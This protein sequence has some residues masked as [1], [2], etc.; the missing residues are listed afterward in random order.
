M[1]PPCNR[2]MATMNLL[3]T[4]SDPS[5]RGF[6]LWARQDSNLRPTDYES[7]SERFADLGE[8][9]E[10]A[11]DLG[12]VCSLVVG[13][14]H[15]FWTNRVLSASWAW[16]DD[17]RPRGWYIRNSLSQRCARH[18]QRHIWAAEVAGCV[19]GPS[20]QLNSLGPDAAHAGAL[21][22]APVPGCVRFLRQPRCRR[23]EVA[24]RDEIR[25]GRGVLRSRGLPRTG[26][27]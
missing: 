13:I 5:T 15:W 18:A 14:L 22:T 16:T 27:A 20:K 2:R 7:V 21:V 6:P 8:A 1:Q 17:G 26:R 3:E 12:F 23:L 11:P 9:V 24:D 4:Q 19:L 10:T 25:C